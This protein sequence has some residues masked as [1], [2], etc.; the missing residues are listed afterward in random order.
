MSKVTKMEVASPEPFYLWKDF[1][2]PTRSLYS[3]MLCM[4]R[5]VK[6][7]VFC[8]AQC[9]WALRPISTTFLCRI[10]WTVSGVQPGKILGTSLKKHSAKPSH[11]IQ[12]GNQSPAASAAGATY[13]FT[14][15]RGR[16]CGHRRWAHQPY[17]EG[18]SI[19]LTDF[20]SASSI[21]MDIWLDVI[22]QAI[23]DVK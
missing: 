14:Q 1:W 4:G 2:Y 10:W 5:C 19:F 11:F 15:R 9:E 6:S 20:S 3:Q 23:S 13:P 16:L 22:T 21:C 18:M 17:I 8:V 12:R 7:S